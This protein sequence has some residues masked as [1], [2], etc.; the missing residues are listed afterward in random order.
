MGK[1]HSL[2]RHM[3]GMIILG[4]SFSTSLP[5]AENNVLFGYSMDGWPV[6]ASRIVQGE[7]AGVQGFCANLWNHL[8]RNGYQL[9]G[10]ELRFDTRFVAFA[11]GLNGRAGIECGPSSLTPERRVLLQP[12]DGKF[13]GVFSQP[14]AVTSTKLL[15]RNTKLDTFY[16]DPAP[17][18]IGVLQVTGNV[19][20]VTTTALI[21]QVFPSAQIKPLG[22]R[23]EAVERLLKSAVADDAIDAY[24]SDEILLR[25]ILDNPNEI[26]LAVRDQYS[27]DPPLSG[28]SREEYAIVVYNAPDLLGKVNAWLDSDAGRQ[29]AAALQPET[30]TF[31]RSLAWL[32]RTDHLV[33]ARLLLSAAALLGA[34]LGA[35]GILLFVWRSRRRVAL[36]KQP[37]VSEPA[38]PSEAV[39]V[40]PDMI[41]QAESPEPDLLVTPLSASLS[42]SSI[43]TPQQLR[44]ARLWA[45]GHQAGVIAKMLEIGSARTVESHLRAIYQRTSTTNRIELFKYLQER[46]LL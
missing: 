44:V 42:D 23:K 32:D 24:A 36:P 19:L 22:S 45:N 37:L 14:F 5:A 13:K 30:D 26:P 39:V 20:P 28:F 9:E 33:K 43:L 7:I 41:M 8:E 46:E 16:T 10:Q 40:S 3:L 34:V 25:G 12:T 15:M 6:S 38:A 27:I 31:T 21:A 4:S 1:R 18:R 17:I 11:K 2:K 35:I 29:A